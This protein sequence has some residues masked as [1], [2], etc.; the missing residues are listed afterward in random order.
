MRVARPS[1]DAVSRPHLRES[2]AP[3]VLLEDP[4]A[5]ARLQFAFTAATHYMF[6]ALTLGLAPY[7]LFT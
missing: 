6:V 1:A 3:T 4:L 7:I 2:K 5:L